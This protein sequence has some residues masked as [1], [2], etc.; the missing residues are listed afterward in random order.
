MVFAIADNTLRFIYSLLTT[1]QLEFQKL[2][3]TFKI[4]MKLLNIQ[5]NLNF[6]QQILL[7][8]YKHFIWDPFVLCGQ[9]ESGGPSPTV[10]GPFV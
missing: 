6:T 7:K 8:N 3:D 10:L 5:L 9:V 4:S 2:S 1:K